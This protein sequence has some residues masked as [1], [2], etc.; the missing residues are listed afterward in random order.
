M[1]KRAKAVIEGILQGWL[2]LHIHTIFPLERAAEAHHQLEERKTTG[3]LLLKP[4][5]H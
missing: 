3:K 4:A 5:F 1:L 2:K